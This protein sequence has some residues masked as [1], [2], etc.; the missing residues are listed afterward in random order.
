MGNC[1]MTENQVADSF[2]SG[3]PLIGKSILNLSLQA[4]SWYRDLWKLEEWP[5]G[6]GTTMEQIIFRGDM[7]AIEEGFDN[8]T[9][10][11]NNTGVDPCLGPNCAYN[12][13]TLGGHSFERKQTT[14]MR[15]DFRSNPF[16]VRF[17]QTT[18]Q[19]ESVFAQI[20]N[21]LYMQI[22]F[23]KEINIG[24]NYL[25]GIAKKYVFDGEGPKPNTANPYVYRAK[26]TA[27][28]SALN[29][30]ML[31]LMYEQMRR[32][33]DCIP[34]D[35]VDGAPVYALTASPQL[36]QRLYRDDPS[37]RK[38]VRFSPM[39]ADLVQKYNFMSTIMGMFFPVPYLW[40]R[41]FRY[42][43]DN[44]K[45]VRV[46]PYVRQFPTESGAHA[47]MNPLYEDPS[48]A[49]H[50]ELLLHGKW[51]FTAY[52]HPTVETLGE[53]SSFGP[54]PQGFFDTW[55]W[56]N[57]ETPQDPGR[58]EGFY[59]T[60]AEIGISA[61]FSE[62]VFG[63][64]VP[65][66][67]LSMSIAYYPP[68]L[69]PPAD[70]SCSNT[71]PAVSCPNP[72]VLAITQSPVDSTHY[73]VTLAAPLDADV[74]D[75]VNLGL[76][77]GGYIIG[78]VIAASSDTRSFEFTFNVT[79]PTCADHVVEIYTGVSILCTSKVL[80]YYID[81]TDATRLYL[82]LDRPIKADTA[83]DTVTLY[84]GNGTTQSATVVSAS[85]ATNL[86]RVDVGST[87][88]QDEVGG[89]LAICCPTAT[90]ATCPACGSAP[91]ETQCS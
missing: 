31:E 90:D 64:L 38:D 61:Q 66:P 40:P 73:F 70:S 88:W 43:S 25:T 33:P 59:W 45:W 3:A 58:R 47:T 78:T 35:V 71:V 65:R 27:T 36:L 24:Q 5:Q 68:A 67:P 7:P 89:I 69:C 19:Y 10:Q 51:P 22:N 84:Y 46:F 80:S 44:S 79:P 26:G 63:I 48:H 91:V 21:N 9:A 29:I 20:V 37:L 17:I 83:S 15:R 77:T 14:L 75:T 74:D 76:S 86:W 6:A 81:A 57:P 34:Y 12:W 72:I 50:E 54:E 16:C 4:P 60:S 18:H 39:A 30:G 1:L 8:W 28:L 85:M 52:Y 49:T 23:F 87:N 62:G 11:D 53:N 2:L 42:D 13:T 32:I 41:R 55:Q 82:T 56:S